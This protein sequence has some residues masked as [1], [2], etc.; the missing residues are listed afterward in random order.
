MAMQVF[1]EYIRNYVLC[2]KNYNYKMEA[3]SI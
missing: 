3:D 2:G 1:K